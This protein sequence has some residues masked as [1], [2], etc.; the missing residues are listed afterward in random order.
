MTNAQFIHSDKLIKWMFYILLIV[1]LIPIWQSHYFVTNDGPSHIYNAAVLKDLLWNN[2]SEFYYQYYE[3]NTELE[4][5]WFNHIAY[6]ILQ[7][8]FPAFLAEKVFLTIY[9]FGFVLGIK[10][11]SK[12]IN[13]QA[14]WIVVLAMPLVYH[15]VLVMGFFNCSFSFV[16]AIFVIGYWLKH[17]D[18]FNYINA[19]KL[20]LLLI[21][22]YFT[23]PMG[24]IMATST[25]AILFVAHAIQ[26][27]QSKENISKS[28]ARGGWLFL[29]NIPA[30]SFM[31]AYML[32]ADQLVLAI[33]TS[34][35]QLY[36]ML[37]E[38]DTLNYL[39]INEKVVGISFSLLLG[40]L[41]LWGI[42]VK[43][44]LKKI[45]FLDSFGLIFFLYVIIYFCMPGAM[46][47]GSFFIERMQFMIF[48]TLIF[49]LAN[50]P[51]NKWVIRIGAGLM[52]IIGSSLIIMRIPIYQELSET[53]QEITSAH[54]YIEE[55][56]TVLPLIYEYA[57]ID[58]EG[59]V[60]CTAWACM[61]IAS[62]IGTQKSIVKLNNYE[63]NTGYFPLLYKEELNPYWKL[64]NIHGN[65][66]IPDIHGYSEEQGQIDYILQV[67]YP[68][69][70]K[71]HEGVLNSAKEIESK[72][73]QTFVSENGRAILYKLN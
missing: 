23:H 38:A 15:K 6:L 73:T 51:F 13:P 56:S 43:I 8:I 63:A 3:L 66:P 47:G 30:L 37:I 14:T 68:G 29:A 52:F 39:S 33:P 26:K 65:P 35:K 32:R 59:K 16:F 10:R 61:H 42:I 11:L 60:I 1:L 31:I 7:H 55:E 71:N 2:H 24:L 12:H 41:T 58:E 72:Y 69:P 5:N 20:S 54:E 40:S 9:V 62:Y 19:I 34:T 49:W 45:S 25:L 44:R 53:A 4:P 67:F 36:H 18:S 17:R 27:I 50:V 57:G 48:I 70:W 46:A 22:T 64:G 21:L 28:L